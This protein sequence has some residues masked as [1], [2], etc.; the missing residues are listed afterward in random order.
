MQ[1]A[2]GTLPIVASSFIEW[3]RMLAQLLHISNNGPSKGVMLATRYWHWHEESSAL[4]KA[5]S[6]F[7]PKLSQ[8]SPM[9]GVLEHWAQE[10]HLSYLSEVLSSRTT[11]THLIS[12]SIRERCHLVEQSRAGKARRA[13]LDFGY[14]VI[15]KQNL[16]ISTTRPAR[17]CVETKFL[18]SS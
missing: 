3:L 2:S 10:V 8:L 1:W 14:I 9:S 13:V 16:F 5:F 7:S 15:T 4:G 6:V 17:R 12:A 11:V 18:P